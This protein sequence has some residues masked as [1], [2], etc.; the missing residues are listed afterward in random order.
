[1]ENVANCPGIDG[2]RIVKKTY[3]VCHHVPLQQPGIYYIVSSMVALALEREDLLIPDTVRNDKGQV[4][5]CTGFCKV[6]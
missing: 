3:N 1:M 4:V 2:V 6:V 5:G